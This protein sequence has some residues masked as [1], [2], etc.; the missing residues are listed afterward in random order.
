V[1]EGFQRQSYIFGIVF[2]VLFFFF[3]FAPRMLG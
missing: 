3:F 1:G 2:F